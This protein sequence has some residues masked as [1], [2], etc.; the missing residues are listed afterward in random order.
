MSATTPDWRVV[1]I[2]S[3]NG[4]VQSGNRPLPEPMLTQIYVPIWRYLALLCQ[5][6]DPGDAYLFHSSAIVGSGN[7]LSP[8][9]RNVWRP[10]AGPPFTNMV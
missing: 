6:V 8:F 5:H 1:N 4:M 10:T 2:G 7:G 9:R 3:N